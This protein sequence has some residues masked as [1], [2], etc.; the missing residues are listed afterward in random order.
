[1]EIA[2]ICAGVSMNTVPVVA[3][4]FDFMVLTLEIPVVIIDAEAP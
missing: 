1:V 3:L 4:N 2:V